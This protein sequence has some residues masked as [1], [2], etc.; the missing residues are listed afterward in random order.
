MPK[1]LE[2]NIPHYYTDAFSEMVQDAINFSKLMTVEYAFMRDEEDATDERRLEMTHA[3]EEADEKIDTYT[4]IQRIVSDDNN[5]ENLHVYQ[6]PVGP[7]SFNAIEQQLGD[8]GARIYYPIDI[9]RY[10]TL[11]ETFKSKIYGFFLETQNHVKEDVH[12]LYIYYSLVPGFKK[13]RPVARFV[14]KSPVEGAES[15]L[16]HIDYLDA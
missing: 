6:Y 2:I 16:V 11:M 12:T 1:D 3:I 5:P 14:R 8:D 7:D 15:Y 13:D 9:E 10:A 4:I